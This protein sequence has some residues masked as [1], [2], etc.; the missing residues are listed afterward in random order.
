M[1]KHILVPSDGSQLSQDAALKAIALAKSESARL[2]AITVTP[3]FRAAVG[4]FVITGNTEELYNEESAKRAAGY[5]DFIR[6]AAEASGVA[7][8]GMHVFHEQPYAAIIEAAR[9]NKCDLICMASHGR[10]G[11]SALVMGSETMKVLTHTNLP[12]LVWR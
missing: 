10:K 11:V 4:E 2:T 6:K 7:V 1:F 8:R 9:G 5:L 12:V 3:P